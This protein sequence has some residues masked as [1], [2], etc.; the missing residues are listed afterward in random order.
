MKATKTRIACRIVSILAGCAVL[1]WVA[2]GSSC[3]GGT[4]EDGVHLVRMATLFNP[5]HHLAKKLAWTKTELEK[6][7]GGRFKC[8][9]YDSSVLGGEKQN[10]ED[11]L[12]GNLELMN[13]AGSYYYNFCPETS[14]LELPAYGWKDREEARDALKG[15]WDK[16]IE[17]SK[18]KGFYPVALDIRDYWG[19]FYREPITSVEQIKNAKFR[20]V[21]AP[22]WTQLTTVCGA[23]PQQIPYAETYLAFKNGVADG[24]LGSVTGGASARWHE[25]LKGYL[26]ARLVL[27]ESFTLTSDKWLQALPEDL[28]TIFLEVCTD[29]EEYNLMEVKAQFEMNRKKLL[30]AGVEWVDYEDL[31]MTELSKKIRTFRDNYMREQGPEAYKFYQEWL[32]YVEQKT[33]RPQRSES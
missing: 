30:D 6:R 14:V 21:N 28:R 4:S 23:V 12:A 1:G 5:D 16:F 25:V 2:L 24:S 18:K 29:S 11:L 17:V 33:G 19:I 26:D 8:E 10:L 3:T 20:S 9:V 15:Y 27:S 31:D 32:V 7:S 13:G 22:L